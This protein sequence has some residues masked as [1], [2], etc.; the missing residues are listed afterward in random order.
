MLHQAI[1]PAIRYVLL[2][3]GFDCWFYDNVV[4]MLSQSLDASKN[5]LVLDMVVHTY[6]P[7]MEGA[8]A[9]RSKVQGQPGLHR[10]ILS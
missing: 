3:S 6:N 5:H 2:M 4:N 8:E 9:G 10:E 7:S 1:S